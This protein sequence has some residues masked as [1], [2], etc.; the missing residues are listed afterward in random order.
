MAMQITDSEVKCVTLIEV[1]GHVDSK[2]APQLAAYLLEAV[3]NGKT[4][5]VLDLE[6][7][8]WLSSSALREI[9][10]ARDLCRAKGGDLRLANPSAEAGEVLDLARL[11]AIFEIFDTQAEAVRSF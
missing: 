8:S 10:T 9:I 3:K 6:K 7:V 2:S 4:N 1:S 5:I 11:S